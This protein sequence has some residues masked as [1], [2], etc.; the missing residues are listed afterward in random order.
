[1]TTSADRFGDQFGGEQ[2]WG[3]KELAYPEP[4]ALVPQTMGWVVLALVLV[5]ILFWWL[6]RLR[7]RWLAD[8]WRRRALERLNKLEKQP[9]LMGE[10]PLILRWSALQSR[11]RVEVAGLSGQA[12]IDWLNRTAGRDLFH[13]EDARALD[14]LAYQ[15]A[16]DTHDVM[17]AAEFQRL[18]RSCRDWVRSHRAAV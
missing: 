16:D 10:L 5:G 3:L 14:R 17:P 18:W 13:P 1:M 11:P 15:S 7:Q 8:A 6:W 12:W 4:V 2:M 9:G